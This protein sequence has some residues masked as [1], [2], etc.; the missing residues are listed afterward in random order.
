MKDLGKHL[1]IL[2][3]QDLTEVLESL[4][5]E[6]VSKEMEKVVFQE[7]NSPLLTRYEVAKMLGISLPTLLHWEKHGVIPKP[8]RFSKRVCL[9]RQSFLQFLQLS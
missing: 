9:L 8:K 5:G 2:V 7:S 4:I 3:K 6:A 1:I